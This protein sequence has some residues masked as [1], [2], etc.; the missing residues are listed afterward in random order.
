L[1]LGPDPRLEW[2]PLLDDPFSVVLPARRFGVVTA[3]W[4]H[5]RPHIDALVEAIRAAAGLRP[6]G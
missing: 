1:P 2:T 4:R 3:G 6:A 5:R